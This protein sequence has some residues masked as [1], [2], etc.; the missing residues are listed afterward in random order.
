ML[1]SLRSLRLPGG[2]GSALTLWSTASRSGLGM[3]TLCRNAQDRLLL[4]VIRAAER[5][6][7]V[8]SRW[9]GACNCGHIQVYSQPLGAWD[10]EQV[11]HRG[12]LYTSI[13]RSQQWRGYRDLPSQILYR[14]PGLE[15]SIATKHL[16]M[17]EIRLKVA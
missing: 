14:R 17:H 2:Q 5:D 9:R 8:G 11:H 12:W 6:H 10:A 3:Q 4:I 1:C 15:E 7:L 16:C 13:V